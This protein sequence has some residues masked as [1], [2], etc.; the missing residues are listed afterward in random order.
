MGIYADPQLF[1]GVSFKYDEVKHIIEYPE[2][3]EIAIAIGTPNTLENIWSEYFI[4]R[5]CNIYF[6]RSETIYVIGI[7]LDNEISL[8]QL[9]DICKNSDII[10][11]IKK[12]SE[13]FNLP[14]KEAKILYYADIG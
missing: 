11:T 5:A 6:D 1:Y 9:I 14:L 10:E 7:E 13:S 4:G 8:E 12:E 3:K 2:I